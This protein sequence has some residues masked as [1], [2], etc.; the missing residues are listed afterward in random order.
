MRCMSRWCVL[1][2]TAGVLCMP[3]RA[4]ADAY[5]SPWAGVHF[6]NESVHAGLRS[7]GVSIGEAGNGPIGVETNLSF[8]PGFFDGGQS[9]YELD[10][11]AGVTVGPTLTL[12]GKSTRPY[13]VGEVGMI[14]TSIESNTIGGRFART[15]FG[16]A[17]GVGVM[18]D[19]TERVRFRGDLRYLRSLNSDEGANS[20][21]VDVG[22]FHFWRLAFGVVL[23]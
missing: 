19:V 17:A 1:V 10:F 15:D 18:H 13:V 2:A 4:R 22:S 11:M 8:A 23:H 16:V 14:R 7:F 12:S 5:I 21:G 9:S 6:G 3:A 20:L